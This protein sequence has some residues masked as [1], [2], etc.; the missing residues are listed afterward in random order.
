ME[1]LKVALKDSELSANYAKE[2]T[3]VLQMIECYKQFASCFMI[4][5]E[6]YFKRDVSIKN[7]NDMDSKESWRSKNPR[8]NTTIVK[9]KDKENWRSLKPDSATSKNVFSRYPKADVK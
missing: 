3:E 2:M 8:R 1:K 5:K 4:K 9:S 6:N 7:N